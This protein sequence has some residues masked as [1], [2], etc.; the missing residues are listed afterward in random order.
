MCVKPWK[1]QIHVETQ[2]KD[3]VKKTQSW[4]LPYC[5]PIR[6]CQKDCMQK[7]DKQK[8]YYVNIYIYIYNVIHALNV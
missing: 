4:F 2:W 8:L 1:S 6:L 7:T 3:G 5:E